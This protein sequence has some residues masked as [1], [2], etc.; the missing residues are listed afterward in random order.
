[1]PTQ[2][3]TLWQKCIVLI[4]ALLLLYWGK[5]LFIPLGF[6]LLLALIFYPVCKWLE[7]KG[8]SKSGAIAF[9]LSLVTLLGL[10]FVSLFLWQVSLLRTDIPFLIEKFQ[11]QAPAY[12][13]WIAAQLRVSIEEQNQWIQ[14]WPM[15]VLGWLGHS[16]NN[17][18]SGLFMLFIAPVFMALFLYN[19]RDFVEA[20]IA[21]YGV[22]QE[23]AIRKVLD[24]TSFTYYRFIKGMVWVYIIVGILNALGLWALGIKHAVL[25]GMLC[26]VMTI[27]PY[28]GII[29]SALLP[30]SVA[31]LEYNSLWMPLAVV[32]LFAFVQYL[33]ANIIF[34]KV[35]GS[36]LNLSTWATLVAVIAGGILWGVAGM[37][38]FIPFLAILKII[39]DHLPAWR[40]L[41]ILLRREESI[42]KK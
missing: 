32:A 36:Q 20:L 34:P 2:L 14:R 30:I 24:A 27:I 21:Y 37:I 3:T 15:T 35:V 31:W 22:D 5:T 39:T 18:S 9:C 33:E 6:G 7:Q 12:Q 1:M 13:E 16:L 38:L 4:S 29:I 19:R 23:A 25:F 17:A 40:P 28:V 11:L 26:A 10:A 42:K 41:H 8:W